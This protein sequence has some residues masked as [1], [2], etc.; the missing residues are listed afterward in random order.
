M[1]LKVTIPKNELDLPY[2][3]YWPDSTVSSAS[4]PG[5]VDHGPTLGPITSK[6][7]YR[8]SCHFLA[9]NEGRRYDFTQIPVYLT[10]LL[11]QSSRVPGRTAGLTL[12]GHSIME[13]YDHMQ[14]AKKP[15]YV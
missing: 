9:S 4:N 2:Q 7:L 11:A 1:I 6:S 15:S 8:G 10:R 13:T 14:A 3:G 5:A 12:N